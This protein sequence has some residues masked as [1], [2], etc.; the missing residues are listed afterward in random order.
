MVATDDLRQRLGDRVKRRRSQ[1]G[2][3][4][5]DLADRLGLDDSTVRAIE[6]GRRGVSMDTLVALA[7]ALAVPAGSL[8]DDEPT[9][10]HG[11]DAEAARIVRALDPSWQ[12]A[13]VTIL[14][15]IRDQASRSGRGEGTS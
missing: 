4:Q 11:L 2:L 6:A 3:R 7:S 13:A 15:T 5:A 14:V 9:S 8:I 1:L 12:R 10:D